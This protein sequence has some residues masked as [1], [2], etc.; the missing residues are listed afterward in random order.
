[1]MYDTKCAYCGKPMKTYAKNKRGD[2]P[3]VY[4]TKACE[5]NAKYDKRFDK[6]F[7]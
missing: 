7:K 1:M 2:L 5:Q 4:D 6:R 3:V